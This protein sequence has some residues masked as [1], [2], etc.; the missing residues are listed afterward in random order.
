MVSNVAA[1]TIWLTYWAAS[2]GGGAVAVGEVIGGNLP[3][4]ADSIGGGLIRFWC[5]CVKLLAVGFLYSYFWTASTAI[6][7]LLRLDN[8]NKEMDEVFVEDDEDEP[9]YALP[10]LTHRRGRSAGGGGRG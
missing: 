9:P 3:D 1:A 6:Y 4:S 10:P 2:L 5:G 8:D 7:L